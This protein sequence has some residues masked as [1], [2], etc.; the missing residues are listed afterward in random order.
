MYDGA[1]DT[2]DQP[3][4]LSHMNSGQCPENQS[5]ILLRCTCSEHQEMFVC[6]MFT[7]WKYT[8]QFGRGAAPGEEL[9]GGHDAK[10][11][12]RKPLCL[13][14]VKMTGDH[15]RLRNKC[16]VRFEINNYRVWT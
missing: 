9:A 3:K 5:R 11:A 7:R 8:A 12:Q 10:G 4:P 14:Y 16:Y 13:Q 1:F 15:G 6:E 2:L